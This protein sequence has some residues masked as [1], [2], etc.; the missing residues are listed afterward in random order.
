[1]PTG[2]KSPLGIICALAMFAAAG[3]AASHLARYGSIIPDTE[4]TKAFET[5]HPDPD[6]TYYISGSEVYPNAI[7]GLRKGYTLDST[8]WKKR[9]MT[10]QM[11][12][13]FAMNMQRKALVIHGFAL[14]DDK[15]KRIGVWYSIL[16]ATT[17]LRM[18]NDHTVVIPT[19]ALGTYEKME[20][21]PLRRIR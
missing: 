18:K 5:Y 13:E 2:L 4:V 20:R 9:E 15:G 7:M 16:S 12:R 17:S 21:W 8:L 11:L 10:P 1:M 3:C 19:P 6:L 14:V